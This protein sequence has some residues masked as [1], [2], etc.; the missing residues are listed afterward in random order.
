MKKIVIY[1]YTGSAKDVI[2][3][4]DTEEYEIL[5]IIDDAIEAH[6]CIPWVEGI[7]VKPL[8]SINN[9]DY[10]YVIIS[11]PWHYKSMMAHLDSVGIN[12]EKVVVW[13]SVEKVNRLDQRIAYLRLCTDQI[14]ERGIDGACAEVGVYKGEF[15]KYINRF[16]PDR[17]LYLFDTFKG[18]GNQNI[19]DIEK[20]KSSLALD[21]FCDTTIK[22]VLKKM[23][24]P[25]K[26]MVCEGYFPQTAENIED[27]FA[28]V[29]LDAD[30]YE[31]ILS[32]LKYFYPKLAKGGYIFVHDFGGYRWPGVKMAVNEYCKQHNIPIVPILD[33]CLSVIITK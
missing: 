26:C 16:M 29:S 18:F 28:L 7:E 4:L 3:S 5:G 23:K 13:K 11:A 20:Q 10:D 15:A 21:D 9:L 25:E 22:E 2:Y 33:R 30:L 32:G 19:L 1:G 6:G 27:K 24:F 12:K 31:P 14:K 17:K 8:E